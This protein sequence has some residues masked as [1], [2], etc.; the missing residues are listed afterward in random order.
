MENERLIVFVEHNKE[1][2]KKVQNLLER[3]WMVDPSLDEKGNIIFHH[4][5][6]RHR[7]FLS[8]DPTG[9]VP[10]CNAWFETSPED[11]EKLQEHVNDKSILLIGGGISLRDMKDDERFQPRVMINADPFLSDK[12]LE[13]FENDPEYC[14]SALVD[15]AEDNFADRL[16]EKTGYECE[17]IEECGF[18]EILTSYSLPY[19]IRGMEGLE[20]F[21]N[22]SLSLL[23]RGGR[24]VI[25]PVEIPY[26]AG[27]ASS[28]L[29]VLGKRMVESVEEL[30]YVNIREKFIEM[31]EEINNGSYTFDV[32]EET[33]TLVITRL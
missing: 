15:I 27:K 29:G 6:C 17:N 21:I 10:L 14:Q 33:S 26:I 31:L 25:Y 18:D 3:K 5:V 19:Y 9:G 24:L 16:K 22:Q 7:S 20:N 13:S 28:D 12:D 1:A 23:K 4:G 30:K 2:I 11:I 8:P 32:N